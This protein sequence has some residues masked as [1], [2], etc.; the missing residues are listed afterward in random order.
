[1]QVWANGRW[2][3]IVSVMN[4]FGVF[5]I[6]SLAIE[7]V[8][9]VFGRKPKKDRSKEQFEFAVIY[10][11]FWVLGLVAIAVAIHEIYF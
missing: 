8:A 7:A 10:I 1:M 3:W 11:I 2:S 4:P 6:L 9:R 5:D